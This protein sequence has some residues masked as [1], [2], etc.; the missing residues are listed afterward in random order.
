V[1]DSWKA[2][3]HVF[4]HFVGNAARLAKL[5]R[6][7]QESHLWWVIMIQVKVLN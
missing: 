3:G 7:L 6:E 1:A 4:K 2:I 5:R